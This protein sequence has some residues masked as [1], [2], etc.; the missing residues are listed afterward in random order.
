MTGQQQTREPPHSPYLRE[1]WQGAILREILLIKSEVSGDPGN[2]NNH[3][4]GHLD[5]PG[6]REAL[7]CSELRSVRELR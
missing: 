4:L 5:T 1:L 3:S 6:H 2:K 7:T